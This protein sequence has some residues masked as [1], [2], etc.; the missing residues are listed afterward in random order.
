MNKTLIIAE[1]GVNHNGDIIT[2][3][4]LIDFASG[5]GADVVKFQTFKTELGITRGAKKAQYQS[6]TTDND[7]S[8][9]NMIK[10]L[11]LSYSEFEELSKYCKQ[12]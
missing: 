5:I 4:K 10:K 8:Q 9:F 3:K 2:A 12:N 1:A 7:E 11:E 6:N